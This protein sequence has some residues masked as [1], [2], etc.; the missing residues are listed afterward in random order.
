MTDLVG[1]GGKC[2]LGYAGGR[3]SGWGEEMEEDERKEGENGGSGG[4]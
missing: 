3:G 4:R 2:L 1:K